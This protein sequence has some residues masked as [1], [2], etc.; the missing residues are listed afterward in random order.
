[1][2]KRSYLTWK[3]TY[4]ESNLAVVCCGHTAHSFMDS[5]AW[6]SG[7]SATIETFC[8]R[9]RSEEDLPRRLRNSLSSIHGPYLF[10]PHP[11]KYCCRSHNIMNI[12]FVFCQISS[13]SS[14][15]SW[16]PQSI[17]IYIFIYIYSICFRSFW[18]SGAP[19]F[20]PLVF[21]GKEARLWCHRPSWAIEGWWCR[22]PAL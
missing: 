17:Y 16:S 12:L 14:W 22:A 9:G 21:I 20:H 4:R 8:A 13:S 11:P 3:K 5:L 15:S 18:R 1:M 2:D 10:A 7:Q 19:C 6:T